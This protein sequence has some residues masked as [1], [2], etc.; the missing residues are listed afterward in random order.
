MATPDV[1]VP[2]VDG[3]P[4][5]AFAAGLVSSG[6]SLLSADAVA[7]GIN[8][9]TPTWG[10]FQGG[11]SIVDAESVTGVEYRKE[12]MIADYPMEQGAFATYNKVKMPFD[13][14]L[15]FTSGTD[16]AARA[17]LIASLAAIA[18]D[19]N[20]YDVV[21]PETVYT[22]VNVAHQD[23]R[24]T[25]RNGVGLLTV[26]VW[27]LQIQTP[28]TSPGSATAQPDGATPVPGGGVTATAPSASEISQ[29]N[30][31]MSSGEI[32]PDFPVIQGGP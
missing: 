9:L 7:I 18:D 25:A 5:V 2:D 21:T 16:T 6:L 31:A 22:N 1:V 10:L 8:A 26:D 30:A 24:R 13:V 3:V 20:L 17:A 15:R 19:V 11:A 12:S 27:C 23:Y 14:R 29:W 28:Q 4:A 32:Q